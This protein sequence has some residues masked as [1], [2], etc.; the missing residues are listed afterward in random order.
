M[1]EDTGIENFYLLMEQIDELQDSFGEIIGPMIT[2]FR[3]MS[4]W[5]NLCMGMVQIIFFGIALFAFIESSKDGIQFSYYLFGAMGI[6]GVKNI[7]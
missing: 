2:C 3:V 4:Y 5:F 1:F 6:A 7:I